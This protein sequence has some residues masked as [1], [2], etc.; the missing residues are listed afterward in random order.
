MGVMIQIT[1]RIALDERELREEFVRS[2]GP[3]GQ[4][5]NK[6]STAVQL[7][8]DVLHSPSLPDDVRVRLIQKAG[9]RLNQEGVLI[10]EARRFRTQEQN[11]QEARERLV[12]LIREA[13]P[14][15]RPRK[16]TKPTAAARERRLETKRRRSQ[17]KSQRKP[18]AW[19]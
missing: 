2:A 5:V 4:H 11:R 12:G 10:I 9:K 18:A 19:T 3:G 13:A 14:P 1:D 6:V 17:T 8:F 16:K 15:P 7:Y